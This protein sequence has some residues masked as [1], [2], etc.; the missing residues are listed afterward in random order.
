MQWVWHQT[1]STV[2]L[3]YRVSQT[4][5]Y[6]SY[7]AFK[8]ALVVG[9]HATNDIEHLRKN[10]SRKP[11]I[12]CDMKDDYNLPPDSVCMGVSDTAPLGA[13]VGQKK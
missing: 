9:L 12:N 2:F 6:V 8:R 1:R 3:P 4:C 10:N 11:S 5:F 13:R 7:A